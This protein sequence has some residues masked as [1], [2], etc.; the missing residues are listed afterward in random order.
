MKNPVKKFS[1]NLKGRDFVISD[2]HGAYG[3]FR[4][5]LEKINFDPLVDR[6]FSVGDL[7]D[8]GPNSKKCLELLYEPWFNAVFAN[9]EQLMVDCFNGG[10]TGVYWYGNGGAWGMEAVNDY[11]A[12]GTRT[13]SD[14]SQEIIDMLELI[15]EMPFLITVETKGGKKYH[16]IHAE[17]PTGAGK[18]TDEMLEDP[19]KVREL[20]TIRVGDGDAFLWGRAIFRSYHGVDLRDPENKEDILRQLYH[21]RKRHEVFHEDLSHVISGH[22]IMNAPLTIVGQTNIDTCAYGSIYV[23]APP[24]STSSRVPPKWAALTCIE[25]DTWKFYQATETE[26]REVEPVVFT[27]EE[28]LAAEPEEKVHTPTFE[29][30]DF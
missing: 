12:K 23:P 18:I 29:D 21:E 5:L 19:A 2:L 6:I 11:H 3:V 1:P 22:T 15:D 27:R 25:L 30:Y 4:N 20:A 9:H 13:P 8:R 16:I 7:I 24:Y 10:R 14:Q 17:L 26:F 28:I